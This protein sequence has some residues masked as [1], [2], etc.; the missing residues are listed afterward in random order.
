ME[1]ADEEVRK[2]GVEGWVDGFRIAE[3]NGCN[4]RRSPGKPPDPK[5]TGKRLLKSMT[6]FADPPTPN[7]A[8]IECSEK[9]DILM[10]LC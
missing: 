6:S 4:F 10:H 5:K 3:R 8:N 2:L 9:S 7:L 1:E